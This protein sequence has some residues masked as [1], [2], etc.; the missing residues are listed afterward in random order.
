MRFYNWVCR[1]FERKKALPIETVHGI[2]TIPFGKY[3]ITVEHNNV[4]IVSIIEE[5][6]LFVTIKYQSN[7][8][9]SNQEYFSFLDIRANYYY[10]A[11]I[12]QYPFSNLIHVGWRLSSILYWDSK[13]DIFSCTLNSHNIKFNSKCYIFSNLTFGIQ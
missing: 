12:D 2:D 9:W 7:N 11:T 1:D 6:E 8:S 13:K 5:A 4:C 10:I 3:S